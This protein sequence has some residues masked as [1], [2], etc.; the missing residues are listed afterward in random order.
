MRTVSRRGAAGRWRELRPTAVL[1][2]LTAL[3]LVAAGLVSCRTGGGAAPSARPE[4]LRLA[5]EPDLRVRIVPRTD[6]V[7]LRTENGAGLRLTDP[8]G[9]AETIA[10]SGAVRVAAGGR[11]FEVEAP[12][13]GRAMR[14]WA[15]VA[16]GDDPIVVETSDS[17]IT[18]GETVELRRVATGA[19]P[20]FDVIAI[21]PMERYLV[22]VLAGE[23]Y[24]SWEPAAYEA[25]AIAARSYALHERRR[26]R[27]AGRRYD[28]EGSALDQVFAGAVENRTARDAVRATRGMV[29][30]DGPGTARA[31]GTAGVLRAYY[32]ST[33]GGRG[34]D[35]A[36]IWPVTPET[37]FNLAEPLNAEPRDCPCD[38]SPLYRW[39]RRRGVDEL[40]ARLRSW[41]RATGHGVM[42]IGRPVSIRR[43]AE[44]AA[45]RPER[46]EIRD[47]DGREH[48]LTAEEL[49]VGLNAR[50]PDLEP[51]GRDR[52]V[53]S[54]DLG[55][56]IRG[57]EIVLD[58]RGFG[59]G[60]GLCQFGAQGY[61]LRGVEPRDMLERFYPGSS[62]ATLY[63]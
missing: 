17:A 45:G 2:S 9:G 62:I 37:R 55:A 27:A 13:V 34:A 15:V 11:G 26:S 25:Q 44:N 61:A 29:L 14:A 28:I 24:A 22:G 35:A 63:E 31:L 10:V 20:R 47:A 21:L 5:G 40:R 7:R 3:T 12:G 46:Y 59:H 58:G 23:L 54:G 53:P 57:D 41:G 50:A 8:D 43:T 16:R 36:G 56:E 38:A 32:S 30:L 51:I 6:A 60:V 1:V 33:C 4:G 48:S 19:E 39:E 18:V 42:L 49:R 52:R